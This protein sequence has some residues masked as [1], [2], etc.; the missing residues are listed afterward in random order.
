MNY[1]NIIFKLLNL[2]SI[3]KDSPMQLGHSCWAGIIISFSQAFT[4]E[5]FLLESPENV[6]RT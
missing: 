6:F 1:L 3:D 5:V 4:D 2:E